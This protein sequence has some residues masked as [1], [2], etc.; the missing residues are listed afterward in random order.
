MAK[1]RIIPVHTDWGSWYMVQVWRWW[2]PAWMCAMSWRE[3]DYFD[4]R[5]QAEAY[6]D[7]RHPGW[8]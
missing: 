1:F 5:Q 4:T 8:R 2:L 3:S 6:L 7:E